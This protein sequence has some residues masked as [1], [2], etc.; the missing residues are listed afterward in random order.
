MISALRLGL[1][2]VPALS[3]SLAAAQVTAPAAL[4]AEAQGFNKACMDNASSTHNVIQ[5][6]DRLIYSCGG[7][8]AQSYFEYLVSK[9]TTQTVDKQ[10]TG[11]YY[12]REIPQSGRCWNKIEH[13]DGVE[14]SWFGCSINVAKSSQSATR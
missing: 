9:N 10:P 14:T 12:F 4:P 6:G 7:A 13:V 3:C 2:C 8:S 5:T 11:T 1:L